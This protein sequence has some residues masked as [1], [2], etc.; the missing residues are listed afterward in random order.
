MKS[1]LNVHWKEWYWSWSSNT[2]ATW[3]KKPSHWKRPCCWERLRARGEGGDRGWD[4][5]MASPTQRTW[6]WANFGSQ[7]RTAEPGMLQSMGSQRVRHNWATEHYTRKHCSVAW[8]YLTLRS[9]GLPCARLLCP[10]LSP[11]VCSNSCPLSCWC[12]LTISSSAPLFCFCFRSFPASGSFPMS[13]LFTSGGQNVRDL[14]SASILPVNIQGWFPELGLTDLILQSRGL[15]TVICWAGARSC[16]EHSLQN[17]LIFLNFVI[18]T[19]QIPT[20]VWISILINIAQFFILSLR[21]SKANISPIF[22]SLPG[23]GFNFSAVST[24]RNES[25]DDNLFCNLDFSILVS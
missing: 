7:W 3:H 6:V 12:Y 1:T 11:G 21:I 18:Q 23:S 8:S 15:S 24:L 10:P 17:I 4:G 5:W 22:A 13:Q 9:Y 19:C 2:L 25:I 20:P 14:A 16:C